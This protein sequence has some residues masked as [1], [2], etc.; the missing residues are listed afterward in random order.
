MSPKINKINDI[1]FCYL[2]AFTVLDFEDI[3]SFNGFYKGDVRESLINCTSY[4]NRAPV[5]TIASWLSS[6]EAVYCILHNQ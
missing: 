6:Q 2:L 4:V 1:V 5:V 3:L